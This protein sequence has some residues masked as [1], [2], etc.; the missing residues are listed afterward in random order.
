MN[1]YSFWR[2]LHIFIEKQEIFYQKFLFLLSLMFLCIPYLLKVIISSDILF[3]SLL[4]NF[5]IYVILNKKIFGR[6]I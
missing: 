2:F 1:I 6:E 4:Q 3:L 5:I